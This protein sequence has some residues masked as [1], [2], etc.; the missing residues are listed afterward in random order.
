LAI[1]RAARDAVRKA[2]IL[3]DALGLCIRDVNTASFGTGTSTSVDKRFDAAAFGSTPILP[4]QGQ[5]TATVT[6]SVGFGPCD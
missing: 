1:Q 2:R 5:V 6:L 4:G 3:L